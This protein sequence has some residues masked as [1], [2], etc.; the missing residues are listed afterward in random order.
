MYN[1]LRKIH[2]YAGLIILMFLMMY[3]VSGYIMRIAPGSYG[4]QHPRGRP[5]HSTSTAPFRCSNGRP[6]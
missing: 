6:M 4:C 3:F 2:L 5:W 1:L